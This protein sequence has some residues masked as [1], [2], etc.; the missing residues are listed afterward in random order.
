MFYSLFL[1]LILCVA[2]PA[3]NPE[4][5]QWEMSIDTYP[6][7]LCFGD[8]IYVMV[9][10]KNR[11]DKPRRILVF[12]TE[13]YSYTQYSVRMTISD[14]DDV[15]Q[16]PVF[17]ETDSNSIVS[18]IRMPCIV[19]PGDG[20]IVFYERLQFPPLEDMDT[21]FWKNI[22][23]STSEGKSVEL[24]LNCHCQLEKP[25]GRDKPI[26]VTVRKKFTI[27]QREEKEM[28]LLRTWYSQTPEEF[29]PVTEIC[30]TGNGRKY[31]KGDVGS[32]VYLEDRYIQVQDRQLPLFYFLSWANRT[33]PQGFCPETWQGWK[34]LEDS[35][36]PSTMRDEIRLTRII[37]QYF[38]TMDANVLTELKEWFAGMN[39]AQRAVM[40]KSIKENRQ[41]AGF[42]YWN[43][44]LV[45]M[46]DPDNHFLITIEEHDVPYKWETPL[47]WVK[48]N[49]QDIQNMGPAEREE[50]RN[51]LG[52][53]K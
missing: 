24:F 29:F 17:F 23:F 15:L 27:Q 11:T 25:E 22:L 42:E 20:I 36:F 50:L 21:E 53:G 30:S 44:L 13:V 41:Q 19:S 43:P 47:D 32:P 8:H 2:S 9:T 3:L 38:D 16:Y 1:S 6:D 5:S 10:L 33:P 31:G 34:E 39:E 7:T 28:E 51:E 18:R 40:V 37:I 49:L 52:F 12:D 4:D 45:Y 14:A 48:R 46:F 35:L 26:A